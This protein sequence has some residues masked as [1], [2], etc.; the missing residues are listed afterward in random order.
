VIVMS[1]DEFLKR[2]LA[3]LAKILSHSFVAGPTT[4]L[5]SQPSRAILKALDRIKKSP[6]DLDLI[7]I[8]E[9]FAAVVLQSIKDLGVSHEIVNQYGGAIAL[10]HPIG[11]SGT[12]ITGSLAMQLKRLGS[13]RLGAAGIC[14]GGGQGSALVLE[15]L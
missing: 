10:G 6:S 4:Y 15:S 9:A 12:R 2:N 8:N 14:G 7:E 13:G 3:G 1:E 5:H 11:V